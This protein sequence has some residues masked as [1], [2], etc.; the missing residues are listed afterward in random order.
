MWF[1]PSLCTSPVQWFLTLP[2][3]SAHCHLVCPLL[4]RE[5][6][7]PS[8]STDTDFASCQCRE[9]PV[10][11]VWMLGELTLLSPPTELSS[12]PGTSRSCIGVPPEAVREVLQPLCLNTSQQLV[13]VTTPQGKLRNVWEKAIGFSLTCCCCYCC[14]FCLLI[15]IV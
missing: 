2:W 3:S 7:S 6:E 4:V 8:C 12:P 11:S 10:Q 9:R 5:Q 15:Y 1:S 14:L 13:V